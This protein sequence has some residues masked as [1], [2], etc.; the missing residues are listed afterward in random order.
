MDG[1]DDDQPDGRQVR[2]EEDRAGGRVDD[3]GLV[4]RD[5]LADGAARASAARGLDRRRAGRCALPS[6]EVASRA[7]RGARR[8]ASS[9]SRS[10]RDRPRPVRGRDGL[11][12]DLD[13]AAAREADLPRGLVADAEPEHA[14]GAGRPSPSSASWMTRGLDAAARRRSPRTRRPRRRRA[15][16]R[17]GA[18][19][20]PRCGSRWRARR[21]GRRRARRRPA[22]A[23]RRDRGWTSATA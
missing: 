17:A 8:A 20:C 14:R 13:L 9:S 6:S 5:G 4:A 3:G 18:A 10:S 19:S 1:A 12:E 7:A 16:C 22:R 23:R 11:D 21:R 2:L 15:C